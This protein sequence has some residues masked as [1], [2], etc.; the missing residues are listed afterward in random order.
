M[1]WAQLAIALLGEEKA[2]KLSQQQLEL[3]G[4]QYADAQGIALPDIPKIV[5]DQLGPS[6]EGSLAPDEGL[7]AKQLAALG[8]IQNIID[9][10]GLDLSDKASLEE[11]M[12]AATNQQHRAREGVASDAAERGQMNSGNRL[13]MDMNAAQSGA[14]TAR[15]NALDV[16]GMAQRRRLQAIQDSAD[17]AGKLRGEDFNEKDT[18]ARARDL[19][20]E[21][22]AA[23]REKAQY[24]N[25]GIPQQQFANQLSKVSGQ[26]PAANAYAGGL[27]GAATDTR[28]NAAGLGNVVNQLGENTSA[29]NGGG[30]GG[31]NDYSYTYDDLTGNRGGYTDL[32]KDDPNK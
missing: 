25:A 16:G 23:A 21:R 11:A 6:A 24:Y 28:M 15:Q 10:G 14:N 13:V 20:D 29:N 26:A 2:S 1:G 7:R 18:A 12:N 32:S 17:M 30:G 4:K 8:S 19:R 27:A 3:L 9:Q 5:A 22:N 31:G